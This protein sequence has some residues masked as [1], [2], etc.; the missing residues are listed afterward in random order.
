MGSVLGANADGSATAESARGLLMTVFGEF[1]RPAGGSAWTQSLLAV[2]E[3]LG[4]KEKATRQAIARMK[5]RGWLERERVGRRTRWIL[6]PTAL[7]LLASGAERIYGFG[8]TEPGWDGR[9][10]VVLASVPE[11]N[12]H[13][14]YR[15][16]VGLN[17]AGFGSLGNGVWISPWVEREPDAHQLL[18]DLGV[19]EPTIFLAEIGSLGSEQELVAT[20]WDLPG[21]RRQY[22]EFLVGTRAM[23]DIDPS[24]PEAA[25]QL[26]MLV[27][28][29]RRFPFLDPD[30]P[31][32]L[33]PADW[34]GAEAAR[35]FQ[36]ARDRIRPEA[37]SWWDEHESGIGP[38]TN[39]PKS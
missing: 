20:A 5:Q 4:A 18:V 19:T 6:T 39:R 21:L 9:W 29:W 15:M 31:T 33:L 34:P 10:V 13:L 35:R 1:V 16:G 28:Q 7:Q 32:E 27:H 12:R 38:A 22:D 14:R 2:L 37:V 26:T 24:G 3:P 30:L 36:S 11:R 8:R 25:A 23:A 17:W